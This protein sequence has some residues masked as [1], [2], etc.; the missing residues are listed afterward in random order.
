MNK[1]MIFKQ[2]KL[3]LLSLCVML[4][5]SQGFSQEEYSQST[6]VFSSLDELNTIISTSQKE[7][8]FSFEIK[9]TQLTSQTFNINVSGDEKWD[10]IIPNKEIILGSKKSKKVSFTV[11]TLEELGYKRI[12]DSQG[13]SKYELDDE[14]FGEFDFSVLI[15]STSSEDDLE[16]VYSLDVYSPTNLPIEFDLSPSSLV[17]N[18]QFPISVR[19]TADNLDSDLGVNAQISTTLISND[20][21]EF[22]LELKEVLFESEKNVIDVQFKIPQ[23]ISP[24]FYDAMIVVKID[25][26][27]GKTQSWE[28]NEVVEVT[29][30]KKLNAKIS[31]DLNLW[32]YKDIIEVI[33]LGNNNDVYEFTDSLTWYERIFLSTSMNISITDSGHVFSSEIKP[34]ETKTLMISYQYGVLILL[35]LLI[36]IIVTIKTYLTAKNPLDVELEFNS[37]KRVKHE[38]VKSFKVKLGFENIRRDEIDTLRVVFRMPSYLHVKDESFS[39]TPPTKVLKGSS[40][41]KLIWEFKRFEKGDARI[42]GF[43]LM[44]SKGILGDIHFEDLEFEVI[45]KSKSQKFYTKIKTIK[46]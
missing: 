31:S 28:L 25:K 4:A 20:G 24:D 13:L 3:L 17:V 23:N 14:Y 2:I 5:L 34:G 36:L 32:A 37:I 42:L 29:N 26:G 6:L 18:P 7:V 27:N 11:S 10:I 21:G 33:N 12:V 46:G 38:G 30:Y 19:V 45:S 43:E 35:I 16:I 41:Y 39:L 44:N 8:T 22:E 40:K 15:N 9:N 1:M